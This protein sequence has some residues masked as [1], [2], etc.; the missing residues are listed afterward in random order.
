MSVAEMGQCTCGILFAEPMH[1]DPDFLTHVTDG[2]HKR[3]IAME[4]CGPC[5]MGFCKAC[6]KTR[7]SDVQSWKCRCMHDFPLIFN[8]AVVS[9]LSIKLA[10]SEWLANGRPG[11]V[12]LGLEERVNDSS[13]PLKE[14]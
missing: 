1:A 10:W 7:R 2:T 13:S 11:S 14:K 4:T 8:E 12:S 5:F 6:E 9:V 3:S